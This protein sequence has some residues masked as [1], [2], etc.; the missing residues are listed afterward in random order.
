[1]AWLC[2]VLYMCMCCMYVCMCGCTELYHIVCVVY[3]GGLY[4]IASCVAVCYSVLVLIVLCSVVSK[5]MTCC[6]GM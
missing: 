2:L 1:M 5:C 4:G 3:M 6:C